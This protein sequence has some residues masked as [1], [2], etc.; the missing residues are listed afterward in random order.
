MKVKLNEVIIERVDFDCARGLLFTFD[1]PDGDVQKRFRVANRFYLG[2]TPFQ[3]EK[4]LMGIARIIRR[5]R[6][7]MEKLK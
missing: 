3:V 7:R 6:Q 2:A 5:Y 4:G 1:P